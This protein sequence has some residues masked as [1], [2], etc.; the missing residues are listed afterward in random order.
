MLNEPTT[1]ENDK[2]MVE[3]IVDGKVMYTP[4]ADTNSMYHPEMDLV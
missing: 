4:A 1:V 3:P 2:K